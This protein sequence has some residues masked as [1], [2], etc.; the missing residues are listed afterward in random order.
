MITLYDKNDIKIG[1]YKIVAPNG[2]VYI[3]K[4]INIFK[5]WNSYK[6][7]QNC[8]SQVRL[9]R[10]LL[11]YGS[12]NHLFEIIIE[13]EESKLDELEIFYIKEYDSFETRHG[14]NLKGGG[15]GGR[16]AEISKLKIGDANRG[17]KATDETKA[18]ISAAL[19][20]KHKFNHTDESKAKLRAANLG[21]KKSEETLRKMSKSMMG[22]K[23]SEETL[24][25][26]RSWKRKSG[27]KHTDEAKKNMSKAGK[28]RSSHRKG[29]SG[30]YSEETRKKMADSHTGANNHF[31]G[32]KH[33][34]ET[35]KKIQDKR[36]ETIRLKKYKNSF[37][38]VSIPRRIFQQTD[39]NTIYNN[40]EKNKINRHSVNYFI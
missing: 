29:K 38:Q 28:G 32:K 27:H 26:L 8:G 34:P 22:K 7:I 12:E 2:S 13:C 35:I 3:G 20:G 30:I 16:C 18:K 25:K 37:E 36:N 5:R 9:K 6:N 14:L 15:E 4:S 31:F 10:S 21:K 19:K 39:L 11:K 1:V 24:I 33:T 17:R 40:D 23:P